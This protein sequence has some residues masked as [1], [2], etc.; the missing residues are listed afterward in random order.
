MKYSFVSII[1]AALTLVGAFLFVV[2]PELIMRQE[3]FVF[4]TALTAV[5][6]FWFLKE[7]LGWIKALYL[8]ILASVIGFLLELLGV[9]GMTFFSEYSYG[10]FMGY[11]LW[12]VP[13]LIAPSW[14]IATTTAFMAARL[15][16]GFSK[17]VKPLRLF[18]LAALFAVIF[19]LPTEYMAMHV[20]YSW[21]WAESGPILGVPTLNY[22]GWFVVAFL[23]YGLGAGAWRSINRTKCGY[24]DL[25]LVCFSSFGL[26]VFH[27]LLSVF[28]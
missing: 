14:F 1:F 10:D 8:L 23:V 2:N 21:T 6:I 16:L 5:V 3:L 7:Q 17:R 15:V 22:V 27:T 9:H 24:H 11:K 12:D 28:Q 25:Q 19:D 13:V 4:A 18:G 26:L 20:W